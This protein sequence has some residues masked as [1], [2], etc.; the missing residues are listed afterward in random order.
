MTATLERTFHRPIDLACDEHRTMDRWPIRGSQHDLVRQCAGC[1]A[2]RDALLTPE[3][4]CWVKAGRDWTLEQIVSQVAYHE[5]GHA[6]VG[7]L[8]DHPLDEIVVRLDGGRGAV[9]TADDP[10]GWVRWGAYDCVIVETM[11][12]CW[13]GQVASQRRLVEL[14]LT[15]DADRFDAVLG[16]SCDASLVYDL[17]E[18]HQVRPESGMRLARGLVAAEWPAITRLAQ[19]LQVRGR[20]DGAEAAAVAGF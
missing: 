12:M 1:T 19:V 5:A 9:L 3:G 13:A 4:D 11:A 15:S 8:T 16:A 14:G 6:V 7:L 10:S 2:A 17:A 18:E 20:L